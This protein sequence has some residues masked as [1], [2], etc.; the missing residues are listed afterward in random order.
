MI[1]NSILI[2]SNSK[3]EQLAELRK[4]QNNLTT[5]V[6]GSIGLEILKSTTIKDKI[7]QIKTG[8]WT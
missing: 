3:N 4:K 1:D 2:I 7:K 5:L 6:K 8:S